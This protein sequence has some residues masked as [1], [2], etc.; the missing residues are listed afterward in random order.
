M[1]QWGRFACGISFRR[2]PSQ[3]Y[4][5]AQTAISELRIALKHR[6]RYALYVVCGVDAADFVLLLYFL[7]LSPSFPLPIHH[8]IDEFSVF[9][10]QSDVPRLVFSE[11]T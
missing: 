8:H 4:H 11:F 10:V 1:P 6:P 9:V 5:A 2:R 3:S 7:L